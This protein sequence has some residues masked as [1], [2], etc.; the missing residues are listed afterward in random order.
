MQSNIRRDLRVGR[1]T[2]TLFTSGLLILS[3]ACGFAQ[4]QPPAP[5]RQACAA[6][7]ARGIVGQPYSPELAERARRTAGAREVQKIEPGGAFTTDLDSD[8]LD[9]EV[10]RAGIVT[11]LRCG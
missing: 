7:E 3:S 9:I 1:R 11:G 8:R 5:E 10:D 6:G 2:R 4:P